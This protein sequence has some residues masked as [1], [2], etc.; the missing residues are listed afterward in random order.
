MNLSFI[1]GGAPTVYRLSKWLEDY[2]ITHTEQPNPMG[3]T[4]QTLFVI[5][6]VSVGHLTL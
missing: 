3:H 2:A 1:I 6:P 5:V 4:K